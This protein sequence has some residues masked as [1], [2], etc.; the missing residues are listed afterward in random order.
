VALDTRNR[1]AFR[2]R[3]LPPALLSPQALKE[4]LPDPTEQPLPTGVEVLL[5]ISQTAALM[6]SIATSVIVPLMG[7]LNDMDNHTTWR[8]LVGLEPDNELWPGDDVGF[9]DLLRRLSEYRRVVVLSG[10]IHYG[11]AGQMS[12]WKQGLKRLDLA[13]ALEQTLNTAQSCVVRRDGNDEW[14]VIDPESRRMF[15]VRK[16]TDGLNV[17]DED[18]P[19]RIAQFGSSGLK[20]AKDIIITLARGLGFAF[21]VVDL[22]P[23]ERLIWKDSTPAV[24]T[25]PEGGR[26][27]PV[28]RDRL[29][30]EPGPRGRRSGPGGRTSRGASTSSATSG[31]RRSARSSR[32]R[33]RR[34]RSTRRRS[35]ARTARSPTGTATSSTRCASAAACS[36]SRT[37]ASSASSATASG[38]SRGRTSTR[39][40][41]AATRRS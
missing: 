10:E 40:R 16:E 39:I 37:S 29:G 9:E 32:A 28:V 17:Y 1:R 3:Y 27:S 26:F 11:F 18:P 34:R 5:V 35:S 38:S 2:S 19:A 22:T 23:A 30:S 25:P 6:P 20:N 36:T 12:Y 8:N 14:L 7:R 15:L 13:A 41:P 24:I 21:T 4:Q 33:S 31:R